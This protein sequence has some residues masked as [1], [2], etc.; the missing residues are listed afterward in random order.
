MTINLDF[1]VTVIF[2]HALNVSCAQPTRDLFAIAKFLFETLLVSVG[3]GVR[4]NR[5]YFSRINGNLCASKVSQGREGN[6]NSH[7]FPFQG[8]GMGTKSWKFE[9]ID[10]RKSFPHISHMQSAY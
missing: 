2:R 3:M 9:G 6:G 7:S 8:M 5:D 4:G 10:T 1:K